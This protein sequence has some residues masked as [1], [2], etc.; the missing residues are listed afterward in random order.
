MALI[1]EEDLAL[2]AAKRE[3]DVVLVVRP[4][5]AGDEDPVTDFTFLLLERFGQSSTRLGFGANMVSNQILAAA[6]Q[7]DGNGESRASGGRCPSFFSRS[8]AMPDSFL[9]F[10]FIGFELGSGEVS[11]ARRV[12]R[13]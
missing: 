1:T 10:N 8:M 2:E 3:P 4:G 13:R 12:W 9:A 5:C 7:Q 11:P 6:L